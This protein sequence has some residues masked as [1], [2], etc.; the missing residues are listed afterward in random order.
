MAN[1]ILCDESTPT[2]RSRYC[3]IC[4]SSRI[5]YRTTKGNLAN[6]FNRRFKG[7]PTLEITI[8]DFC[9]WRRKI[10]LRCHY[11]DILEKDLPRVRMMSQVQRVVLRMGVDRKDSSKG[12]VE[13]NLVPCCFVCN[14]VKGDRFSEEEM[15]EIGV[16]M[17]N[18]W[19]QRLSDQ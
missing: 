15:A 9:R 19:R 1:C 13:G 16:A 6:G 3:D 11:C 8:D 17:R 18:V 2:A 4:R 7:S 5:L 12:Y 10:E 14:Q